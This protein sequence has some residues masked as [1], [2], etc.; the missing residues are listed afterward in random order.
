MKIRERSMIFLFLDVTFFPY[1][2][3]EVSA[4]SFSSS[5]RFLHLHRSFDARETKL[6]VCFPCTRLDPNINAS[7]ANTI[8]LFEWYQSRVHSIFLS[9]ILLSCDYQGMVLISRL[10]LLTLHAAQATRLGLLYYVLQHI[11]CTFF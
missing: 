5:I 10:D 11:R 8:P 6:L 1:I 2:S 9:Q 4:T 3:K 7:A